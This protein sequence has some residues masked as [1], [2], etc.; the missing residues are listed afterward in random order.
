MPTPLSQRWT[1]PTVGIIIIIIRM[2]SGIQ[3]LCVVL[4]VEWRPS[5]KQSSIDE[6][7]RVRCDAHANAS[8]SVYDHEYQQRKSMRDCL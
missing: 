4:I 8:T 1:G 3:A 5:P 6:M 2:A 7:V